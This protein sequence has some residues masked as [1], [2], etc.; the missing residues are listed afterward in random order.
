MLFYDVQIKDRHDPRS[1]HQSKIIELGALGGS[2]D[3]LRHSAGILGGR[4]P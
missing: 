1:K 4:A 2:G 3:A